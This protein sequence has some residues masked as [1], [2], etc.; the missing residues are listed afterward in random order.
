MTT[1]P[2]TH[3]S[4]FDNFWLPKTLQWFPTPPPIRLTSPPATFFLFPK[5][6]LRLKGSPFDTTEEIHAETRKVIDTLTF[7]DF[8]GCMKSWQTRCDRCIH[9]QKDYFKGNVGN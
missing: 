2:L 8:Q 7:E 6:K 1:H 5:M 3:H 4:L 9:A